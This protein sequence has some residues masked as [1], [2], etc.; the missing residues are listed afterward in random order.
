MAE[1]VKSMLQKFKNKDF[2]LANKNEQS[3]M[4]D[5]LSQVIAEREKKKEMAGSHNKKR[6]MKFGNKIAQKQE[7]RRQKEAQGMNQP[8]GDG[9]GPTMVESIFRPGNDTFKG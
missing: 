9:L 5:L 6:D 1:E 7:V 4:R 3:T 2:V 8:K